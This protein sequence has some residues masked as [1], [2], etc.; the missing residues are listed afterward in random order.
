MPLGTNDTSLR[1]TPGFPSLWSRELH[2]QVCTWERAPRDNTGTLEVFQVRP[3]APTPVEKAFKRLQVLYIGYDAHP[4]CGNS[5]FAATP[6]AQIAVSSKTHTGNVVRIPP[7]FIVQFKLGWT[8]LICLQL[9]SVDMF[10]LGHIYSTVERNTQFRSYVTNVWQML[11]VAQIFWKHSTVCYDVTHSSVSRLY[12]KEKR[13][14][15][16]TS[17]QIPLHT[18]ARFM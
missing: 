7:L 2:N 11:K 17:S 18:A 9:I 4:L 1:G 5:H 6:F 10:T 16:T 15:K 3:V 13:P 14:S 8:K 12:P